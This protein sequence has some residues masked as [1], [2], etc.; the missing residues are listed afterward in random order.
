MLPAPVRAGQDVPESL[1][2]D[3]EF[4]GKIVDENGKNVPKPKVTFINPEV[5]ASVT[6]EGG[7]NGNFEVKKIKPGAYKMIVETP[8][9]VTVRQ[10]VTV[11]AKRGPRLEIV[12]KND[13]SPELLEKATA[14]AQAGDIAGARAEYLKVLEA[15]P[16]L[17]SVNRYVAFTYGREGNNAEALKYLDAALVGTPDDIALLQL[18]ADSALKLNQFPRALG[19]LQKMDFSQV[20]DPA[21]FMNMAI[22]F[23]NAKR[24][25]DAINML[26]RLI[27]RW[28]DAADLYFFRGYANMGLQKPAEAKPDLE[29][30]LELAPAGPRAAEAKKILTENIPAEK[31]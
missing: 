10:D 5:N 13:A 24:Q 21:P 6:V 8:N 16:D 14:L 4:Q 23:I 26:D 15:H 1:K 22:Q 2:G 17:T 28:P 25:Q 30:Y 18:A 19:Y 12:S 27:T 20:T 31:K 29:K 7:G 9:Y 3:A 11:A